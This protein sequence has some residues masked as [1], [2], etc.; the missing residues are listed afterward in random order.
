MSGNIGVTAAWALVVLLCMLLF[1]M[2]EQGLKYWV[3]LVP[4]PFTWALSPIWLLLLVIEA[5]G[6]LIKPVA[7][8]IRLF[9][10]MFAGHTVL[11]V[12]LSL[13]YVL[14]AKQPEGTFIAGSLAVFGW[15]L[16]VVFHFMEL[17][18]AFI[19]AY[20]FTMLAALFIGSSIHPE[21]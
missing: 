8:A 21:H 16:A 4:I 18:V 5:S 20:V 11:L 10:N 14:I 2:K 12:F 6:L 13:G 19:Q 9:A 15:L 7:L 17:L 3:T 1:G